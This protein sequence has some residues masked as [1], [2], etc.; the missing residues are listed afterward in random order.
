MSKSQYQPNQYSEFVKQELAA[1][2]G[3]D[4]IATE[5]LQDVSRQI[6]NQN[7]GIKDFGI[8]SAN[9]LVIA[10]LAKNVYHPKDEYMRG[11]MAQFHTKERG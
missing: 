4:E 1:K 5:W 6:V 11:F 3:Q 2:I 7:Q 8:S 9:E 10:S